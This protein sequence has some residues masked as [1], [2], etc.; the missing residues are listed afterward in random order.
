MDWSAWA[1]HKET[2]GGINATI[3]AV[4]DNYILKKKLRWTN[5]FV[6]PFGPC[7]SAMLPVALSGKGV[8]ALPQVN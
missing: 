5:G 6:Q 4:A 7:N 3:A 1:T 8:A 2:T